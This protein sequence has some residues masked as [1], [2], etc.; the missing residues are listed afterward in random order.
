[1]PSRSRGGGCRPAGSSTSSDLNYGPGLSHLPE[2]FVYNAGENVVFRRLTSTFLSPL[3]TA[4]LLVVAMFFIPLRR[5]WGLR[6]RRV[7]L[8]GDPV[9]AHARR[10]NR[11]RRRA[12]RARARPAPRAL[13]RLGGGGRAGRVRVRQGLRP[14]RAADALHRGRAGRAG[15]ER[16]ED[17]DRLARSDRGG[18]VVDERAPDEPAR[19]REDRA[20]ASV[21]FRARQLRRDRAADERRRSRRASRPTRS[22]ASR[23]GSLGGLVFIAWSLALLARHASAPRRGSERR[24]PRCSCSGCR[25]T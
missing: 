17:A 8:R 14:L 18:R 21:G 19:R 25:R 6:A 11:A 2:N 4:Y 7:A 10:G 15:A 20:E 1:M 23:P 16:L 5:R 3:A 24:S 12:H 22:S 13:P 9:D